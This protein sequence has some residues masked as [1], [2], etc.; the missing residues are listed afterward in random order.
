[1]IFIFDPWWNKAAENQ[2]IDRAHR[3]G[4]TK[5]VTC[6]KLITKGTIEE[7]ILQLQL[8][9]AE[10]FNNIIAGDAASLKSFSQDDINYLMADNK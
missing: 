10:I 8:M 6:Y 7:K 5:K 4:Q 9:K 2:A 1:M 3:I